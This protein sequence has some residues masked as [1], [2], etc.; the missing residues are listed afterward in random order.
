MA[1]ALANL[2]FNE[3]MGLY[4]PLSVGLAFKES[5]GAARNWRR[6][7]IHQ[8]GREMGGGI[9]VVPDGQHIDQ[10]NLVISDASSS[11]SKEI[12]DCQRAHDGLRAR[13]HQSG[14]S[15]IQW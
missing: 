14:V 11:P 12:A 6:L 7:L 10:L 3:D 9:C 5:H 2:F 15:G 1:V 13:R 4:L 8:C